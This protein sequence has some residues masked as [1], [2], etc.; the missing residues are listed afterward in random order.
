MPAAGEAVSALPRPT[1]D[2]LVSLPDAA[3]LV[4]VSK[5]YAY[6][7]AKRGEFPGAIKIGSR[8]RVSL[9]RLEHEIH[10]DAPLAA[11]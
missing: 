3:K 8:W 4:G 5:E 1:L 7:L 6:D 2:G 10:G 11:P 9:R